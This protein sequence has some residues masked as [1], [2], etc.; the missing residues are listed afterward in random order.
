MSFSVI[1][2]TIQCLSNLKNES[3]E[4]VV[5]PWKFSNDVSLILYKHLAMINSLTHKLIHTQSFFG[6]KISLQPHPHIPK[7]NISYYN[8]K[9]PTT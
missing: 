9:Q 4:K 8:V 1:Q 5:A 7:G 6:G 3:A 2:L